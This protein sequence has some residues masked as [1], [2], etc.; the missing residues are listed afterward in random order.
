MT[1]AADAGGESKP[2]YTSVL[3]PAT[4][5]S[6]SYFQIWMGEDAVQYLKETGHEIYCYKGLQDKRKIPPMFHL[7][8][9]GR[10]LTYHL[11][12]YDPELHSNWS[13]PDKTV[14]DFSF[15]FEEDFI[16]NRLGH[17]VTRKELSSNTLSFLN[18][19]FEVLKR[20]KNTKVVL[21]ANDEKRY[22]IYDKLL[23]RIGKPKNILLTRS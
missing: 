1:E 10:I 19:C 5:E 16:E 11:L 13:Y 6:V 21:E 9:R 12:T 17:G 2:S 14:V 4:P 8:D 22:R 3:E 18:F 20:I 15:A 7:R 23:D